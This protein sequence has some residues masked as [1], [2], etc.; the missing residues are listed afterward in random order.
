MGIGY[1][2]Y[3]SKAGTKNNIEYIKMLEVIVDAELKFI[4]ILNI[5]NYGVFLSGLE[6]YD[7]IILAGGD[8]TLNRF[9]NDTEG[10][11]FDNEILYFP[12]GT[13]NDFAHELEHTRECN[14]F[15]I[16]EYLKNM[17]VL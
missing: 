2:L 16:S 8:G 13:G 4:D 7:F 5:K 6:E 15:P 17:R 11:E 3:N 12:N 9:V 14:P 1:V 10:I